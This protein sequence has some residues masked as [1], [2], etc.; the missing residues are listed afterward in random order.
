M[1]SYDYLFKIIVIGDGRVGKT[2]LTFRF[3]TGTFR[4]HYLMTIGV[5]FAVKMLEVNGKMVKL[6]I[7]DTGGQE[8]FSYIRPLYY[9]GAVGALLCF[10]LTNDES[11]MHIPNWI[12]EAR[13]Y[14]GVIPM[15]LVGTKQDLESERQIT[16]E[17]AEAYAK[18]LN[19]PY[20]ETSSKT[21]IAV[22]DVFAA[23]S[24]SIITL[25]E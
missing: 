7:W 9:R 10:D 20:Y 11:F 6:Q 19:I 5:E 22:T 25:S 17:R 15:V 12:N 14:C 2:S 8:R 4:Q 3:S 1:E 13:K 16:K 24:K 18:Q 23:L 21:G